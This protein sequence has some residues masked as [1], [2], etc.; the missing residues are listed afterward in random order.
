MDAITGLKNGGI[1]NET[2]NKTIIKSTTY[3]LQRNRKN[4]YACV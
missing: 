4:W 2:N 1:D 3:D